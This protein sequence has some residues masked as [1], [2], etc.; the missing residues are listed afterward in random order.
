MIN[1][2]TVLAAILLV[3]SLARGET[4]KATILYPL[5][6][7]GEVSIQP[8]QVTADGTV[9]YGPF[10]SSSAPSHA[11]LWSPPDGTVMDLNPTD[12]GDNA[13]SQANGESGNQQVGTFGSSATGGFQPCGALVRHSRFRRGSQSNA[14]RYVRLAC[15]EK[16]W[17]AA[18]GSR[19]S[20]NANELDC[21]CRAMDGDRRISG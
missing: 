4:Y 21:A 19:H 5:M 18:G 11:L 2:F 3:A 13:S 14:T 9:G 20:W 12:F 15:T 10:N 17:L 7:P 6:G 1:H 16:R 8:R